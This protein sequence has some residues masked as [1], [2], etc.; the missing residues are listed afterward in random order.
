MAQVTVRKVD[1]SVVAKA[2]EEAERKGV[3]MN[4]VLREAIGRG[5]GLT[6]EVKTNG[7]EKFS[8]VMP[9]ES[10]QE[11]REWEESMRGFDEIDEN[12]WK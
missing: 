6:E 1:D 3:S 5:L 9:F 7:L 11:E 2:K 8:G 12:L 4:T 10:K